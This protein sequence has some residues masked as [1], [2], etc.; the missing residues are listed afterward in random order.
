[1]RVSSNKSSTIE[2]EPPI[3]RWWNHWRLS[4]V[5]YSPHFPLISKCLQG[6]LLTRI[7]AGELDTQLS[8][9]LSRA[10]YTHG[11]ARAVITPAKKS[12]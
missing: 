8:T 10:T 5:Y 12:S 2:F 3:S 9:W 4:A 1:M 7:A 6:E 11:P